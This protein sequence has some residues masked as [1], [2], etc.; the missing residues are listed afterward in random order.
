MIA[1]TVFKSLDNK[2]RHGTDA[3][4]SKYG[5]AL[6]DAAVGDPYL[7]AV[8]HVELAIGSLDGARFDR[9]REFACEVSVRVR[10]SRIL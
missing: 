3:Y 8:Q 2:D 10:S 6:G 5:E 4:L 1:R 9:L 7:R